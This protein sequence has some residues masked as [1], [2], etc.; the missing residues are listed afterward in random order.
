MHAIYGAFYNG[1]TYYVQCATHAYPASREP[2]WSPIGTD[3]RH[4]GIHD[5]AVLYVPSPWDYD[6]APEAS[7]ASY[8]HAFSML[9][10]TWNHRMLTK[11]FLI[12]AFGFIDE[13][14]VRRMDVMEM[15]I[16][17]EEV[18]L[19]CDDYIPRDWGRFI[20]ISNLRN[21]TGIQSG[22]PLIH[23][24]LVYGIGSFALEKGDEKILVFTDVRDYISNLHYCYWPV[25]QQRWI[26]KYWGVKHPK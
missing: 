21:A 19:D 1:R 12:P 3:Q 22:A 18:L 13:D 25:H 9:L 6:L 17:D 24:G 15:E 16:Y 4:S 10:A 5:L 26:S 7:N 14:H 8:R 20:C 23:R 11:G 2:Y